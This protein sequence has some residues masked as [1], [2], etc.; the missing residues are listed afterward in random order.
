MFLLPFPALPFL[1]VL[2]LFGGRVEGAAQSF[3]AS[4]LNLSIV[5]PFI[6]LSRVCPCHRA[7][8]IYRLPI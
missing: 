2:V 8:R 5:G 7:S 4:I 3:V 1:H 6:V